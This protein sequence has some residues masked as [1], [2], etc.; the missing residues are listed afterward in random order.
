MKS[1]RKVFFVL[2]VV[3]LLAAFA[4]PTFAQLARTVTITE[5]SINQTYRVTNSPRRSVS[6]LYVDLQP[7]QAVITA[8]ITPRS[9]S[10]WNVSV[11]LVPSLSNGRV[12]WTVASATANGQA[13]TS[14]QLAQ[15][16]AAITS[17][18]RNYV[19]GQ[20]GTGRVTGI[21]VTDNAVIINVN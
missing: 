11:T 18:W 3:G 13:A 16:N 2:L 6:N 12:T 20:L 17:S 14:E 15:I 21:S 19:R 1:A 9:G 7:G 10:A 8:T 4:L 5:S